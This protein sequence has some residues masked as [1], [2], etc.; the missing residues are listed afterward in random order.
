MEAR[1][2]KMMKSMTPNKTPKAAPVQRDP[3]EP[4]SMAQPVEEEVKE[5]VQEENKAEEVTT[6]Q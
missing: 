1:L 2:E 3:V 6:K 5:P 4:V